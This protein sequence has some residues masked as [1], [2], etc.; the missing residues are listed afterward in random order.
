[1]NKITPGMGRAIFAISVL[2]VWLGADIAKVNDPVL[3]SSLVA[4]LSSTGFFHAA[5]LG[6]NKSPNEKES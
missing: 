6:H 4:A 5:S 2:G 1:M 3:I